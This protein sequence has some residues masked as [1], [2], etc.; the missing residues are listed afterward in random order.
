[1]T[2][3]HVEGSAPTAR[4][5]VRSV[6][7]VRDMR[8]LLLGFTT[9]RTGDFLYGV[10]LVV[11]VAE[12]TGSAAW[13]GA[14]SLARL[15]PVALLSPV[16]G[17]IGDRLPARRLLVTCDLGQAAAM[18]GMAVVVAAGGS[19]YLV[20]ALAA[21]SSALSTPYFP[22]V[23]SLTPR[24]VAEYQLAATNT[25]TSTV[26]NLAL[27]LGPAV[28]GVLLLIGPPSV[29]IGLNAL[30][31]LASAAFTAAVSFSGRAGDPTGAGAHGAEGTNERR[32]FLG[33]LAVGLRA[34]LGDRVVAILVLF[35]SAVTFVYG[36]ELVYLVFVADERLGLGAAGIG[37]LN[38]ALGFGGAAGALLTSRLANSPRVRL[39]LGLTLLGCGL[40]LALLSVIT[41]PWL[42]YL[43]LALEGVASIALD[44]AIITALQRTV[45]PG[46]LA[47]VTSILGSLTV[48]AIL[49]GNVAA[50]GLLSAT[51]LTVSLVVS[52]VLLPVLGVLLL[53][54][55]RELEERTAG[56][57]A[58]LAPVVEVLRA[59][60]LLDDAGPT[61]VERLAAVATPEVVA[62]GTLL[63]RQGDE[64][65]DVFVLASGTLDASVDGARVNRIE[66]PGY[67]GEIGLVQHRRR[68]A[69]VSAVT[70]AV[71]YRIPG[72]EF[73]GA[74]TEA[75]P[76]ALQTEMAVRLDR[77]RAGTRSS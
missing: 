49:L 14:A 37:Y 29:P 54:S 65:R 67:V 46:L 45:A 69:S 27:I 42:A 77:S 44:V 56:R 23:T 2:S 31:F 62:A 38:A 6:F 32:T 64:A 21:V 73:M 52:G 24:L 70:D 50:V 66:A 13:V 48:L 60:R 53:P 40:P 18:V 72:E 11:F 47:R 19:P 51:S 39:V 34:T 61:V 3:S 68:T 10:A 63:L 58:E 4:S 9:S 36:F 1:M 30:T 20:L 76:V 35:T 41:A 33:E 71:I 17:V 8:L 22:V 7:A 5:G 55:L 25:F 75:V 28:G 16:A 26:E 15:V 43:V 74:V 12:T 57:A 59:S